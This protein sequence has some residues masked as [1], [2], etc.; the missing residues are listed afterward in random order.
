MKKQV[1]KNDLRLMV[2]KH[3]TNMSIAQINEIIFTFIIN[4]FL[5]IL[6]LGSVMF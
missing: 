3:I 4:N 2:F 6:L 5:L 1:E